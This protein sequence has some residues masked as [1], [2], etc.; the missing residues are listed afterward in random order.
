M[1]ARARA[2]GFV[3]GITDII[4]KKCATVVIEMEAIMEDGIRMGM[5]DLFLEQGKI[6]FEKV[7]KD[8]FPEIVGL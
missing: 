6:R 4:K 5:V 7:L 8:L 1:N 2:D 3:H